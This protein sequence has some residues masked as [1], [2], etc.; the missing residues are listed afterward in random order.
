MGYI[1][2]QN[3]NSARVETYLATLAIVISTSLDNM[4]TLSPSNG[5]NLD[6]DFTGATEPEW[7]GVVVQML[8]VGSFYVI[9]LGLIIDIFELFASIASDMVPNMTLP[10]VIFFLGM[11][12]YHLGLF[13]QDA[14]YWFGYFLK[15]D[16]EDYDFDNRELQRR[17]DLLFAV[18]QVVMTLYFIMQIVLFY[19]IIS[20]YLA[21]PMT[22][23]TEEKAPE[24]ERSAQTFKRNEV[25]TRTS[26][27]N[28]RHV[29]R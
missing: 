28:T 29:G 15:D 27:R 6:G 17:Y 16:N 5:Y 21:N 10:T 7:I 12:L 26:R 11:I 14:G 1:V 2:K 8:S 24:V 22:E 25:V 19:K 4:D 3:W 20:V 13:F 23:I 18:T 9:R